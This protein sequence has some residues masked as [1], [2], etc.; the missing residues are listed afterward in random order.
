[1]KDLVVL[2]ADKNMEEA[3]KTLLEQRTKAMGIR[4]ITKDVFVHIHRDPGVLNGAHDFLAPFT[5]Q[6]RYALVLFDREGCGEEY[7]S[8]EVLEDE[9]LQ[10]L[11]QSGWG[12]RAAVVVIDPELEVWVWS[13]SPH[14]ATI[15]GLDQTTLAT[16]LQGYSRPNHP[17]PTQPK[18]VMEEALRQSYTPRSASLYGELASRVSLIHCIDPAFQR[19]RTCLQ[20]WFTREE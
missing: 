19:L 14:V 2:V 20:Q 12:G 17:K 9:V 13:G 5:S 4:S 8:A 16:V 10:R 6:Y 1:M 3:I 7:K 18:E 15:L 11:A